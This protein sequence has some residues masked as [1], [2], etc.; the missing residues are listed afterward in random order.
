MEVAILLLA[1]PAI[2]AVSGTSMGISAA[3]D[4]MKR[5]R[6]YKKFMK[7]KKKQADTVGVEIHSGPA[8]SHPQNQHQINPNLPL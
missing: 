6:R 5:K 8:D 2:F 3:V 7:N 1:V 4:N